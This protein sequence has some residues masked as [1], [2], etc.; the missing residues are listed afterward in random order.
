[1]KKK[2]ALFDFDGTITSRD[3]LLDIA[4][5]SKGPMLFF[6][7]ICRLVPSFF[8]FKFKKISNHQFKEK[9]LE[10][11]FKG[12]SLT[13]FEKLCLEY[14]EKRLPKIIRSKALKKIR[15]LKNE[16]IE[17]A[18]VSASPELW[19]KP[20]AQLNG[21]SRVIAT[22]LEFE[23]GVLT[24]KLGGLNCYGYEKAERVKQNY[25][26]DDYYI[27]A[28]GDSRGDKELLELAKEPYYR[29]F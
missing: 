10:L 15:D 26:I 28:F 20:W 12:N 4:L 11:F 22:E 24:G 14:T 17:L 5:Y 9:F 1:M 16:N 8:F 19:I 25:N 23:N 6:L 7:T 3:T 13:T 2:L 21:F 27:L 29:V 18:I